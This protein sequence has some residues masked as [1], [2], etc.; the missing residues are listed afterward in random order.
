MAGTS[1]PGLC[2]NNYS[3]LGPANPN[4]ALSAAGVQP[5]PRRHGPR[6]E[7]AQEMWKG[8]DEKER[9]ECCGT[10]WMMGFGL[11]FRPSLKRF[12]F[13]SGDHSPEM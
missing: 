12:V 5:F 13:K 10:I 8:L 1:S 9:A 3:Q 4:F 2:V 7:H 6:A 11:Y